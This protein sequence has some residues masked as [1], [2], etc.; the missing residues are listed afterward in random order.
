MDSPIQSYACHSTQHRPRKTT[1]AF[2]LF[3]L[4]LLFFF[5][6]PEL[7]VLRG[8]FRFILCAIASSLIKILLLLSFFVDAIDA[9]PLPVRDARAAVSPVCRFTP[10]S[11]RIRTDFLRGVPS[12]HYLQRFTPEV[13][14]KKK[15]LERT[16]AALRN[17]SVPSNRDDLDVLGV[18]GVSIRRTVRRAKRTAST[19]IP[20]CR[21]EELDLLVWLTTAR[22]YWLSIQTGLLK[23]EPSPI[24]GSVLR[25][26][27]RLNSFE[28]MPRRSVQE[29]ISRSSRA[30]IFR[31][32]LFV[33]KNDETSCCRV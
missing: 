17:K 19:V 26:G 11:K 22:G 32:L 15:L 12:L 18:N 30:S 7:V 9:S 1:Q 23:G 13:V 4:Y 33:D 24:P 27:A 5:S 28:R 8:R 29:R 20:G 10:I 16:D 31:T 3:K 21:R 2:L 25:G 6:A 14:L